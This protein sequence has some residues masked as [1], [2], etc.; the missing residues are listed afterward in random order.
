MLL[1]VY[2]MAMGPLMPVISTCVQV[3]PT[4]HING[5]ADQG[6]KH[7][8]MWYFA[9]SGIPPLLGSLR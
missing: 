2:S 5:D 7:H 4:L 3:L 1:C 6:A 9:G 8:G